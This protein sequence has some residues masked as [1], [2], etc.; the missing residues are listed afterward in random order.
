MLTSLLDSWFKMDVGE[1]AFYA[2]FGFLFVAVGITILVLLFTALGKVMKTVQARR[3]EKQNAVPAPS[4]APETQI[5][6]GIP[7]EVIAAITAAVAAVY[8]GENVQCDFVVRRI[9]KL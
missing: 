4:P 5:Q 8:E 6:E 1:G 3:A 2:V 9:Q 7:P